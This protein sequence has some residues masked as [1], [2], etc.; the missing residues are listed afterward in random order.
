MLNVLC[1]VEIH[2]KVKI[3]QKIMEV[4]QVNLQ[5]QETPVVHQ[6]ILQETQVVHQMLLQETLVV[7]LQVVI[8]LVEKIPQVMMLL[9]EK[10]PLMK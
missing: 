8:H 7:I 1:K 4:R 3:Q 9:V 2:A 10:I 5:D 6:V